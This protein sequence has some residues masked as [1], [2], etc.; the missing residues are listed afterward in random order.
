MIRRQCP[1]LAVEGDAALPLC[2]EAGTTTHACIS[3]PGRKRLVPPGWSLE[4]GGRLSPQGKAMPL[5]W[6]AK[7]EGWGGVDVGKGVQ[8]GPG[9][10]EGPGVQEEPSK[11]RGPCRISRTSEALEI[12]C[13]R[14]AVTHLGAPPASLPAPCGTLGRVPMS[15][16][17]LLVAAP[18]PGESLPLQFSLQPQSSAGEGGESEAQLTLLGC[19][20][21]IPTHF[22]QVQNLHVSLAVSPSAAGAQTSST[23]WSLISYYRRLIVDLQ[24]SPTCCVLLLQCPPPPLTQSSGS[25]QPPCRSHV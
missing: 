8:E 22:N 5:R 12:G 7:P 14:T 10:C 16:H 1:S 20:L 19:R 21:S 17:T 6:E 25:T 3:L 4:V 9:L 15:T 11:R 2:Q 18:P 13:C 24:M 23:S